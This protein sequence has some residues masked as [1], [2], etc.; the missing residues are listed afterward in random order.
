M[1]KYQV[2][3]DEFGKC[4]M[5]KTNWATEFKK[6]II[7]NNITVLRLSHSAGWRTKNLDFME[8]LVDLTCLKCIQIF[9]WDVEDLTPLYMHNTLTGLY[10]DVTLKQKFNLQKFPYL[11][12]LGITFTPKVIG[13][14]ECHNLG[15]LNVDRYPY[16]SFVE[17]AKLK[18]LKK[19]HIISRKLVSTKG[20]S[21]FKDLHT[22]HF[23]DCRKLVS[24]EELDTAVNLTSIELNACKHIKDFEILGI[25]PNLDTLKLDNCGELKNIR[26]LEKCKKLRRLFLRGTYVGDRDLSVISELPNLQD[27]AFAERRDNSLTTEQ[28]KKI[29]EQRKK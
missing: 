24:L 26:F 22:L 1:E 6:V 15:Y 20:I 14:P 27:A 10:F 28:I 8:N 23:Y 9:N 25:L 29:L 16:E 7:E 17:I 2:I 13:L 19:L 21:N 4:L 12:D 11:K 18:K 5:L 3:E